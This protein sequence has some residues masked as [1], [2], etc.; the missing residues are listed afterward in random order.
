MANKLRSGGKEQFWREMLQRQAASGLSVRSVS[1][2]EG[3]SEASF[4]AWR[5]TIA[6]RDGRRGEPTETP[7]ATR[8]LGA[9]PAFLPALVSSEPRRETAITIELAGGRVLRWPESLG[10]ERLA[11]LVRALEAQAAR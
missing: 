3:L 6:T 1:R 7:C 10:A 2:Q 5:R 8:I 4:Y 11:Q 9:P